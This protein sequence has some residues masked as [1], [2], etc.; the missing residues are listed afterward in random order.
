MPLQATSGAASYDAF[1]GGAAAAGPTYIEDVFSTWLY[2]GTG[3]A[4]TITNGIDLAG[5][6]GLVWTKVRNNA[7]SHWLG[8]TARGVGYVLESQSTNQSRALSSYT[9]FN[10]NGY[11]ITQAG[12]DLSGSGKNYV[13]WSLRK[14]PK[15]FDIVTYTGTG[16]NRTIAHNLGSAPG[17][18]IIK[19][20]NAAKDW[21]V[22]HRGL[23]NTKYI[24]LNSTSAQA[25]S[26]SY[27]NNT[28][29]TSTV[30]TV[31]ID[32][33]VNANG[34][35]YVAYLF[36]HNAGGFGLTGTDNVISCGSFTSDVS[37]TASITLG[38]EPQWVMIKSTT[39]ADSWYI[40]DTM[41][42]M[43]APPATTSP[44]LVP[45]TSA[46]EASWGNVNGVNATGWSTAS[47]P[48]SNTFIYIAIRRGPMKVPTTGTSVYKSSLLA[49]NSSTQQITDLNFPP[50]L[51]MT[52][53]RDT[54]YG[55]RWTDRLR[56][57]GRALRSDDVGAELDNTTSGVNPF[58]M[59]GYTV[60]SGNPYN[61]S[62]FNYV[63]HAMRR[64]PS[65]MDV[66]CWTTTQT[67]FGITAITHNLGVV[68]QLII[69]KARNT[70]GNWM[71]RVEGVTGNTSYLRLNS[72]DALTTFTLWGTPTTTTF[73]EDEF[74]A[75]G[76]AGTTA[77][78][79][80][81]ATCA[82][83]SK[84]GTYTGNGSTQ[85]INCGF[86]AGGA[87][88]VLIKRTDSTG[89][90]YVYDT[91]RGM[92]TLTDPYLLFNT[93]DAEVATL[94]SVTTVSTGFALN[95]TILAAINVNAGTY[96]FLAIA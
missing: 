62:G 13:S 78:A 33:D 71:V 45:N 89:D 73:S 35:T 63:N 83:V 29:P 52:K 9:S 17:C 6:G 75:L 14:Q 84:V 86:G 25:T 77:V 26:S 55:N 94:G 51:V 22:Y 93:T 48:A 56:G 37:G 19:K 21:A 92:T 74:G 30:F 28:D 87:R 67:G 3:S 80:L 68:P 60:L 53:A 69:T 50:D 64:A 38:Y 42:G 57:F 96:I 31:G 65:F 10:S 5:K 23:G 91:V 95:S 2:S 47:L 72:T 36:A 44:Y 43:P 27:W 85:T 16:A 90:W 54:S 61:Q 82:G 58:N 7:D 79:Y 24:T 46:A 66:V 20:T 88:F 12:T 59:N 49:G 4:Q 32:G 81:F 8:D 39:T 1:G 41:R 34:D 18:M 11:S 70:S 76:S 40:T 15:F